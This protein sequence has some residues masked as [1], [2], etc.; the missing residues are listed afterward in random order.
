MF[1]MN[2]RQRTPVQFE[3]KVEG[4]SSR[5]ARTCGSRRSTSTADPAGFAA[6]KERMKRIQCLQ[7]DCSVYLNQ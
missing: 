4:A 6:L 3:Q 7:R 2:T 5:S 1:F